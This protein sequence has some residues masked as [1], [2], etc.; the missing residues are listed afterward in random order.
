MSFA[1]ESSFLWV[2][3]KGKF[4]KLKMTWNNHSFS[5]VSGNEI[6][7][8]CILKTMKSDC[9]SSRLQMLE[10]TLVLESL[11]NK[12][13]GFQIFKMFKN[14]FFYR[15]PPVAAF[16]IGIW[17]SPINPFHVTGLF[18]YPLKTPENMLFSNV[19]KGCRKRSVA[20]NGLKIL[21]IRVASLI[22]KVWFY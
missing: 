17:H 7:S 18:L 12:V 2:I 6:L 9:R 15:I 4:I 8:W 22:K 13:A 5:N 20:R 16:L 21:E 19:L 10:K 11:F 1:F 14:T 3:I